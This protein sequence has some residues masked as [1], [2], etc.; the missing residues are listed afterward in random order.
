MADLLSLSEKTA[1]EIDA[2][3]RK[4]SVAHRLDAEIQAELRGH[5]E[6]K[7][8]GYVSGAVKVTEADALLLATSHF[9]EAGVIKGMFQR[10]H[11]AA[12]AVS[13]GR[14]LAAALAASIGVAI[15]TE[16]AQILWGYLVMYPVATMNEALQAPFPQALSIAF[17]ILPTVLEIFF[18]WKIF[19][20][21]RGSR[22]KGRRRILV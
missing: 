13:L 6:D 2:L 1:G 22:R 7:V 14:R 16:I 19:A 15:A 18:L 5:V 11:G 12:H 20:F 9:G 10:V 8:R 21:W 3:A 4:I 17:L